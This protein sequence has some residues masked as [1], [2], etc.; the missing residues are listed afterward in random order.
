M[1][2]ASNEDDPSVGSGIGEQLSVMLDPTPLLGAL[3][4]RVVGRCQVAGR[5]AIMAE[6][7]VRESDPRR[8]PRA[9]ELHQ[10]GSG[11]DRYQLAVDAQRGVL[12]RCGAAGGRAISGDHD[13]RDRV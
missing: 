10:L 12:L 6:A 3:Q 8:P 2:A 9:F 13:G 5:R 11:A 1:G 4:F 7:V